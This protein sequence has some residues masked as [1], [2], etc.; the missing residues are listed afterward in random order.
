MTTLPSVALNANSSIKRE[1]YSIPVPGFLKCM[2]KSISTVV[3]NVQM[4]LPDRP[5]SELR[6][7]AQFT[8]KQMTAM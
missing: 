2:T 4:S 6:S 7:A 5:V 8:L 1:F 3:K